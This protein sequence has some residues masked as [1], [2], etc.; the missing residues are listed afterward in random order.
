M[1]NILTVTL[2]KM[3]LCVCI[4]R[5]VFT[6][7]IG[8]HNIIHFTFD[9]TQNSLECRIPL[10]NNRR[11]ELL[12][13]VYVV[14]P[15]YKSFQ[16]QKVDTHIHTFPVQLGFSSTSILP[17]SLACSSCAYSNTIIG[18]LFWQHHYAK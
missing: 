1:F 3:I 17:L 16:P 12:L 7:N 15:P 13:I 6:K 11:Q 14:T 18:H 10:Q 5:L 2:L 9:F 8:H 4:Q